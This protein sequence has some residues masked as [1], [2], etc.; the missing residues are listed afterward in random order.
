ME[1]FLRRLE[2]LNYLRRH[3]EPV[4]SDALIRHLIDAGYLDEASRQP[5]SQQ[6]LVQRDLQFLLGDFDEETRTHSN[7]FGLQMTRGTGKNQL[8]QLDPYQMIHYD[9]ERMP[10]YMAL[11]LRI[12]Q[13]HLS[14]I[15]P[16]GTRAELQHVFLQAEQKLTASQHK[17][18]SQQYQRLTQAVEFFQRGQRLQAADFDTAVLD[19]IYQAILQ[20]KRLHISYRASASQTKDYELH[21]Y[22]IA[23]MLP[24]L[25]LVATKHSADQPRGPTF[26]SFLLHKIETASL[27]SYSNDVPD[28]FT[29][30]AYLEEGNMDVLIDM[31]DPKRYTLVLDLFVDARHSLLGDLRDSPISPL[32]QLTRLSDTHWQLQAEVRRTIQLRNWLLSLGPLARIQQPAILQE[33]L[34]N[35]LAAMQ[36]RY[37]T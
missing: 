36:A 9:F 4:G 29:M 24:K 16:S 15:L 21:P 12:A 32:Q 18:S 35:W 5:R 13:R 17:I 2:I 23:I 30:K 28:D 11:T 33:D 25:Y 10:A 27:S 34:L 8:W 31:Q 22:G 6:R 1:T 20:G 3:R 26:R 14:P 7:E 19:R 37:Q